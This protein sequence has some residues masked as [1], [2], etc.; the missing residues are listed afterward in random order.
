MNLAD[1]IAHLIAKY[2]SRADKL[3]AL[4]KVF[5]DD[6]QLVVELCSILSIP[7]PKPKPPA[8]IDLIVQFFGAES[9]EWLT[10]RQV[11]EGTGL[12]RATTNY[13][14]FASNHKDR[15]ES[16]MRGP[17][18]KVWRLKTEGENLRLPK[19]PQPVKESKMMG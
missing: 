1:H 19:I 16:Q 12:P 10:A 7:D 3:R 8:A 5:A 9:N 4:Q 14:L 18:K 11:A 13:V 6:P 15:F 17:K 2:E